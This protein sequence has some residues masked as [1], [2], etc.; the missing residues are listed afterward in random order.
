MVFFF[1]IYKYFKAVVRNSA[2]LTFPFDQKN[3]MFASFDD[4]VDFDAK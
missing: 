4:R 3:V 1:F 2:V